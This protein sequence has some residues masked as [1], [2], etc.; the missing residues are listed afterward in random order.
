MFHLLTETSHPALQVREDAEG[1]RTRPVRASVS[2]VLAVRGG[3]VRA[4]GK[5]VQMMTVYTEYLVCRQ[6]RSPGYSEYRWEPTKTDAAQPRKMRHGPSDR[7]IG[8]RRRARSA[9]SSSKSSGVQEM[10]WTT[11]GTRMEL[12]FLP[13][14]LDVCDVFASVSLTWSR[15]TRARSSSAHTFARERRGE[16]REERE[17]SCHV[18]HPSRPVAFRRYQE[19]SNARFKPSRGEQLAGVMS[20]RMQKA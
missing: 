2:T 5:A 9:S 20:R 4:A 19:A 15:R 17:R 13:R 16:S 12:R 7:V 3:T 11:R 6:V 18:C 14:R 10:R 1:S 8:V